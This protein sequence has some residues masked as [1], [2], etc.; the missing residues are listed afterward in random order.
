[1]YVGR[2]MS[3]LSQYSTEEWTDKELAFFHNGMTQVAPYLN[4]EGAAIH[5]QIIKEIEAR[6]GLHH[7]EATWTQGTEV[8]YD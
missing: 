7:K 5:V 8:H 6:G 1:M 2:D 3:E 4:Q